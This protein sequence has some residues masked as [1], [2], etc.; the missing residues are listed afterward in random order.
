[1]E[2]SALKRDFGNKVVFHGGIENQHILPHGTMDQVRKEVITC[3]E[4]LGAGGGYIPSS[5]HNI[6]AGTPPENVI[7]MIE[8]VQT[9][10]G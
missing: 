1:M 8:A 2:R 7:A 9:W 10:N 5:C 6:Q 3:P 4:A